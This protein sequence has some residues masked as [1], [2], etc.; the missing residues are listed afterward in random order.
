MSTLQEQIEA[1]RA[2]LAEQTERRDRCKKTIRNSRA[3]I[4]LAKQQHRLWTKK[5]IE[6]RA[7]LS[8]L[9]ADQKAQNL[10]ERLGV[11]TRCGNAQDVIDA[12]LLRA[13]AMGCEPKDVG[14][15]VQFIDEGGQED[16]ACDAV[17]VYGAGPYI[18]IN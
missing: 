10:Q 3:G 13:E 7:R 18:C 8:K 9:I 4:R 17:D 2:V 5:R 14:L 11:K 12:I 16:H 6:T 1:T 15:A